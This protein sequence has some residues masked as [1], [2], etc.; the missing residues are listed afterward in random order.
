MYL[1]H[2]I[3]K[4]NLLYIMIIN[5]FTKDK[6]YYLFLFTFSHIFTFSLYF[7]WFILLLLK[8]SLL[9]IHLVRVNWWH[10]FSV[11]GFFENILV[12][13]LFRWIFSLGWHLFSTGKL[14]ILH[15]LLTSIFYCWEINF[16]SYNYSF[17]DTICFFLVAFNIFCL[18]STV[19]LYISVC[20]LFFLCSGF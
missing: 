2:T 19:L 18:F 7:P 17:E 20:S 1:E 4:Y 11:F 5:I 14:K 15:W 12:L 8:W 10:I 13:P 6:Y 9:A 16:Y 3:A